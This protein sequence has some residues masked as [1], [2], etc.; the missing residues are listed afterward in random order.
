MALIIQ[1]HEM[2]R[3]KSEDYFKSLHE[4]I[5]AMEKKWKQQFEKVKAEQSNCVNGNQQCKS[6]FYTW[7]NLVVWSS[8]ISLD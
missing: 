6:A 1:N 8:N 7:N 3:G 2:W 5:D 4:Q